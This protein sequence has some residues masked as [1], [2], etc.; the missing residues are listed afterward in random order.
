MPRPYLAYL[1]VYEPLSAFGQD[2]ARQLRAEIDAG[3]LDRSAVGERE[4]ELWLRSQLASPRRLLPGESSLGRGLRDYP[5]DALLLYPEEITEIDSELAQSLPGAEPLVCPL[6][7]RARCAAALVGFMSSA[8]LAL[9][10]AAVDSSFDVVRERAAAALADSG[11]S[12]MHSL[13]STWT[14]PL[15][16]FTLIEPRERYLVLGEQTDPGRE[17]SWRTTM[18]EARSRVVR[19]DTVVCGSIGVDGPGK[20]L[21]DTRRWLQCFDPQS[22]VELDYGGLVQL[23]DDEALLEDSSATDVHAV[24]DAM[25]QGDGEEVALRYEKLQE[26][27]SVL[28][29]REQSS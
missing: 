5:C 16:W 4:R 12:A 15:P 2:A 18:T 7:M 23:L 29:Q 3:G 27:W 6:D 20:I 24:I 17:A 13:C 22:V 11:G 8:E 28:A 10:A 9:Q 21:Q 19:A 26:F 14:V 1:R 25:E